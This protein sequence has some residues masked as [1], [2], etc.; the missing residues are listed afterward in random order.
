M[1]AVHYVKFDAIDQGVVGDRASVCSSI[2]QGFAALFSGSPHV[3]ISH[4]RER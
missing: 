4:G 2:A 1:A 3:S